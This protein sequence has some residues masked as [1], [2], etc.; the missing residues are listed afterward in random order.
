MAPALNGTAHS[1]H[2][3]PAYLFNYIKKGSMVGNS[4]M[5]AFGDELNRQKILAI[6]AYFQ[7]LWP[8]AIRKMYFEKYK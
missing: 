5:P 7:S 2:H 4:S 6:I 1:W 8:E 3:S